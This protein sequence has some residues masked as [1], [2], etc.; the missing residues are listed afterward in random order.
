MSTPD[1]EGKSIGSNM[2]F[3][4]FY[5]RPGFDTLAPSLAYNR[6]YAHLQTMKTAKPCSKRKVCWTDSST[7]SADTSSV[8]DIAERATLTDEAA[9]DLGEAVAEERRYSRGNGQ[10]VSV[11]KVKAKAKP[12][13]KSKAK[14]KS[15]VMAKVK[16]KT[17]K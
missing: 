12:S 16:S 1:D 6:Y 8:Q 15:K 13:S 9:R 10:R 17:F 7:Y 5:N 2:F 3:E 14:S 4:P 11:M